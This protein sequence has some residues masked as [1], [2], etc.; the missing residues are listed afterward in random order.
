MKRFSYET[1]CINADGNDI[2]SMVDKSKD[3][4]YRTFFKYVSR[5][6]VLGIF[7]FYENDSRNGLT[8]KNDFAISYYKSHYQGRSCYFL[9][10]SAIEYIFTET[11]P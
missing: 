6:E 2:G 4:S 1:C 10:H 9:T 8:L 5:E 11:S 3:I 7:P